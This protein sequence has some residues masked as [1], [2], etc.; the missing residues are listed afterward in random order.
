MSESIPKIQLQYFIAYK[1]FITEI[2]LEY[3][4]VVIKLQIEHY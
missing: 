4:T 2:I 3:F 1:F